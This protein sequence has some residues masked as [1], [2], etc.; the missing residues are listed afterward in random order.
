MS[1]LFTGKTPAVKTHP[2]AYL[3]GMSTTVGEALES[4]EL[5]SLPFIFKFSTCFR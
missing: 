1:C 2:S 5:L 3:D 4:K